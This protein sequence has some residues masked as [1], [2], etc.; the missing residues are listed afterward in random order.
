MA[1]LVAERLRLFLDAYE[2]EPWSP[3]GRVDCCL[4]IA[5]WLI[6]LGYPDPAVHLRGTYGAGQGQADVLAA[7]GGAS[8]LIESCVMPLGARRVTLP[9]CG[10]FGAVGS[11]SCL[12]RQFGVIHDGHGWLTRTARGFH[13]LTARPLAIWRL[14]GDS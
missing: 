14:H 7:H 13:R 4:I 3:G 12:T 2:H 10:D 8:A 1:E 9:Q 6:W 11:S 5:E